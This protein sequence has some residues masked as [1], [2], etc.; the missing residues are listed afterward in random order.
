MKGLLVLL[1]CLG[2]FSGCQGR[3]A[4]FPYGP[5]P[6]GETVY[7][8]AFSA[9]PKHLDP[10]RSYSANEIAYT[11]QIYE[12]PLQYD[13]LKRPYTLIPL[14][15]KAM[16]EIRYLDSKGKVLSHKAAE[17]PANVAMTVYTLELR[18]GI[19]Y[20]PHP[21][22][23]Q[24]E[25]GHYPHHHLSEEQLNH[26][27][28]LNDIQPSATREL[29]ADD[30][31]YQ[32]KR[33][34][35]PSVHSPILGLMSAYIVGLKE[36]AQKLNAE[37][38]HGEIDLKRQS[39]DG[40]HS[41][42]RYRYEI[43]IRGKYPQFLY[44]LAM[45]FFAPMPVE[46]EQFY[47][48]PGLAE[49]NIRLDNNPVGTG[50]F[51]MQEN[52]PNARI[53]LIR[54]PNFHGET[55]PR[56]EATEDQALLDLAGHSLPMIDRAV[57]TL[58]KES[59]PY[60]NKFLQGYYDTS[61]ISS[62]SFDQAIQF[63]SGGSAEL[64]SSMKQKGIRLRTAVAPSIYYMGFNMLDP[65][66]GGYGERARKLRQAIS[67]AVD[68]EEYIAIFMN[69]RGIA[70][71]GP[72]PPGIFGYHDG[73]KGINSVV[74]TWNNGHPLRRPLQ[75]A[76]RLLAEAGYPNGVDK[77]T[78][79]QL[80]LHLDTAASGPDDKA[81]LDWWRKQFAKLNIE[82]DIRSTDYNRFQD[83]M[84]NGNAQIFQ[85]G[86][87][88]DYPDPENFLFLLYGPNGKAQ[89]GGENAANYNN[90]EFDNL[91]DQMKSMENG[92]ARKKLIDRMVEIVQQDSPWIWG[93]NPRSFGLSHEWVGPS[94]PNMMANNTLKYVS[95]DPEL[96]RTR[97]QQWNR[98]IWW[99]LAFVALGI[100]ILV[101]PAWVAYRRKLN[102]PALVGR[103]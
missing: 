36:L 60:W 64:R 7:Y 84:L 58:E 97:Q 87:N 5:E 81:R 79:D 23:Y 82:L 70:A 21:A 37:S 103:G 39:L 49:K 29:V 6:A 54:N 45:P 57:Y 72:L 59:I 89:H 69:G 17:N 50:P 8:G 78:G 2:L 76:K 22:F 95:V 92:P 28:S 77:Q 74:Y 62:D 66:V 43:R 12:P 55:Y 13:Y 27:D 65:V 44:W 4:N 56:A 99:P 47:R 71:Q 26:L 16:P 63:S 51:M 11:A 14:T 86:W 80:V 38:D 10:A 94:K 102:A 48:Q 41:L 68:Y 53:V 67:V 15:L 98:V 73:P 31:V 90:A 32:I 93:V 88:A 52:S 18:H 9:P 46:V 33:L 20:Q 34:A 42:D 25:P 91:F 83:K 75:E 40:V 30:Y 24:D 61:G 96:R 101:L 100:A 3:P 85:W 19:R 35:H 1:A